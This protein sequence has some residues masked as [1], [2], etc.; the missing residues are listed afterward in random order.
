MSHNNKKLTGLIASII[1]A[2]SLTTTSNAQ[3]LSVYL[4]APRTSNA[5]FANTTVET[6]NSLTTGNR[7]T[8]FASAIGTY[9]AS[10]TAPINVEAGTV[11]WSFDG[12]THIALGTQS[13]STSPTTLTFSTPQQYFGFA[14]AAGDSNNRLEFFRNNVSIGV[15]SSANIQSILGGTTVT[16]VDNSTYTTSLYKGQPATPT[17]NSGENYAFVNFIGSG[18]VTFDKINFWNVNTST[19]FESDNHTILSSGT[20]TVQNSF[21]Y[22]TSV[23]PSLGAVP[24]PST[25]CLILGAS[26]G[27]F[28]RQL[29]RRKSNN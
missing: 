12:T 16:A 23:S 13:G 28:L 3:T 1:T 11:N 26:G 18:G 27:V 24:E 22:V 4:N 14:W 17:T 5:I 2:I 9:S 29:R 6:F 8:A 21:V 10:S 15:F 7:T 20:V 19:G 25:L